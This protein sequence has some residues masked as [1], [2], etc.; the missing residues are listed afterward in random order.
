MHLRHALRCSRWIIRA[1]APAPAHAPASPSPRIISQTRLQAVVLAA[2]L[3]SVLALLSAAAP[4]PAHADTKYAAMVMDANTGEILHSRHGDAPRFPASLTKMMTLYMTFELLDSKRLSMS[5][6]IKVS[7]QAAARPPSKLGLEVGSTITVEAAIKSLITK[8]AND[9]ATALAEHIAGS[10]E[11]FARLM[12]SRAREL[13]MP[14]T[15]FRNASGL[16]DSEQKSTARDMITLAL[17]L[18]DN[19]PGYYRLFKTRSFTYRGKTYR[20]HNTLLGNV[21]GVDGIKTGYIRAAGFNLVSS[22][23][24]DGR[25]VV[26]AVFGGKSARARNRTMRS[27]LASGLRKASTRRTRKPKPLLIARPKPT[28]KPVAPRQIAAAHA[29]VRRSTV[30]DVSRRIGRAEQQPPQPAA[31]QRPRLAPDI[32]VAKVRRVELSALTAPTRGDS[33]ARPAPSPG[34]QMQPS[35]DRQPLGRAPS[36]LQEQL[37]QLL[38]KSGTTE[39]GPVALASPRPPPRPYGLRGPQFESGSPARGSNAATVD[40]GPYQIQ[41]GAYRTPDEALSQLSSVARLP[42]EALANRPRQALPVQTG[43]RTLYR[44]RFA[45]FAAQSATNACLELRRRSVDCFVVREN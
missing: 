34:T 6:R 24:R 5:S 28:A 27:L 19:F 23:R 35:A 37:S 16:P 41:V 26:A 1:H 33:G 17:A 11:N 40:D 9:V 4:A 25:H 29:P 45:G 31:Q 18:Q 15:T 12:T 13:G 39:S 43:G 32:E 8:S 2:C 44:A 36:T 10:E 14:A 38:A 30:V 7:A 22:I 20:N 21:R 3:A 42:V